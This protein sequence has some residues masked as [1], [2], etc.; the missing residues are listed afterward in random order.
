MLC[1]AP[2]YIRLGKKST[3]NSLRESPPVCLLYSTEKRIVINS[4]EKNVY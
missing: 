2:V 4:K 3:D 1:P